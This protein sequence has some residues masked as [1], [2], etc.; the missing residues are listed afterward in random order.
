MAAFERTYTFDIAHQSI[1]YHR[2]GKGEPVMFIHGITTY[3][4]IWR[5]IVPFFAENYDVIAVDL[6]GCGE[7]SKNIDD[8]YSLKS[9][10]GMLLKLIEHLDLQNV[11]LVC[12]DVGG[13]VG[14]IMAVRH[15]SLFKSITLINTVAYDYW[16]VQPIISMRTPIIRN[17]AMI[18]LDL[19]AF[20]LLVKRGMYH[21]ERVN[22]AL[23]SLFW[24]PMNTSEGRKAFLYFAHCLNNND[25]MELKD[26]L[27]KLALPV[28]IVRG[29][30]DVY[31]QKAISD[32]LY[33]NLPNATYKKIITGGHFI[34]E[35]EPEQLSDLILSF[36]KELNGRG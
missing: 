32:D 12:H 20:R 5:N 18:S 10:A 29:E 33:K 22:D 3:S 30:A 8:S 35:D 16:P 13:G 19:G 28:L 7:S 27:S 23:M 31:L 1:A 15:T 9:H 14:Q 11:H 2:I 21:R 25:L 6:A 34:Q 24:K 17:L 4:F 36:H 26:E